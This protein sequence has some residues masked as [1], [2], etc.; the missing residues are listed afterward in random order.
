MVCLAPILV[1][2]LGLSSREKY[3]KITKRV[4]HS[5]PTENQ[6][7]EELELKI[8]AMALE[9]ERLRIEADKAKASK[10]WIWA[11]VPIVTILAGNFT[12]IWNSLIN[13]FSH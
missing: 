2:I 8:K 10:N 9:N 4:V 5:M 1:A 3:H 13:S 11:F 7:I 6:H 12:H